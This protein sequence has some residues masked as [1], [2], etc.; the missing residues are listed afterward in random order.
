MKKGFLIVDTTH[1]WEKK[2]LVTRSDSSG[3]YDLYIC[4]RCRITGKRFGLGEI[5]Q[6]DGPKGLV[7]NCNVDV[8][9]TKVLSNI[10]IDVGEVTGKVLKD[11]LLVEFGPSW[12]GDKILKHLDDPVVEVHKTVDGKWP[13][14]KYAKNVIYWFELET[15]WAVGIN[16]GPKK[17]TY[18][19]VRMKLD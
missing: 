11:L 3:M 17:V 14:S 8:G 4:N 10:S 5:V 19:V 1:D 9:K 2:S 6:A 15:G 16:E 7:E 12:K 18:P 13:G